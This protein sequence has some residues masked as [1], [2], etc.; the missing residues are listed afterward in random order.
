M[1]KINLD[2]VDDKGRNSVGKNRL[3]FKTIAV[4]LPFL[5]LF[6]I[7]I[8][9]RVFHYG[10]DL[11][12]FIP[13]ANHPD[14]LVLNPAASRKYF[15]NESFAPTGNSELFKKEKDPSTLRIFVLGESTTIGYPFFHNGSFHRWLQYRLM[16]TFPDR[17]F[18]IINLSLTAV[19]SYTVLGFARE[20]VPYKPDA[21]LIY[22][23][24]NEFYG[25]LGVGSSNRIGNSTHINR[26]MLVLRELRLVQLLTNVYE[27]I[28]NL[29]KS[30]KK[31]AGQTLMQRMVGDQRIP[32]G[33]ELYYQGVKQFV[34]NMNETLELFNR[35]HIPVFVSNL[36]CNERNLKPFVSIS[37]DSARFPEFGK[38]LKL[39]MYAYDRGEWTAADQYLQLAEKIYSAHALCNFYLG[40]LAVMQGDQI[41]AGFYFNRA[42]DMDGLRFRAPSLIND[43]IS[44]LCNKYPYAHLVDTKTAF[45]DSSTCGITG[46][47]LMM[48]H[49]HPNLTGYAI[50]SD[51]FYKALKKEKIIDP[52]KEDEWNLR[53][54]VQNMP[55]TTV[56]SLTGLMRILRLKS[57]WPFNATPGR[58]SLVPVTVEE[59]LADSIAF[60]KMNWANAMNVLYN[61]YLDRHDLSGAKTVMETLV[62]EHPTEALLYDQTATIC[63]KQGNLA[64]AAFYFR[65][66]FALSP[67]FANAKTLFVIYLKLD[68][69]ALAMPYLNYAIQNNASNVNFLPVKKYAGEVIGLKKEFDKDS[70]NLP[71]LNLIANTYLNM[72]NKDGAA[73]YLNKILR[74]DPKNKSA[75]IMME[76][77]KKG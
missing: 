7:E 15:I 24:H 5:L 22:T 20:L 67:S 23:G 53:Q 33:S 11:N 52:V 61:Y 34:S 68:Q 42:K 45:D 36:V 70:T 43:T 3:I 38:N 51:V 48:E 76:Q 40:N 9:L 69:P 35:N 19:N 13:A 29:P 75:L 26:M 16:H 55:I 60:H 66:A 59:R 28:K 71:V 37:P 2:P 44:K 27:K 50:M 10:N 1:N 58:D 18:E 21:V 73:K 57:N 6:A 77:V 65:K 63:G 39:G 31:Y 46:D 32:Y 74:A 14:Y 62:L 56:D 25:T 30:E 4:L 12:L 64:D 54:L 41:K 47:E 72:G 49:V 8:A 17:Q